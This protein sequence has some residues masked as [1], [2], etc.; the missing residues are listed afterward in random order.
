MDTTTHA[1]QEVIDKMTK[2]ARLCFENRIIDNILRT[3]MITHYPHI[4]LRGF[5]PSI[6]YSKYTI[7]NSRNDIEVAYN[8]N[9]ENSQC[10]KMQKEFDHLIYMT[11]EEIRHRQQ[12]E[13]QWNEWEDI[14]VKHGTTTQIPISTYRDHM[15][16]NYLHMIAYACINRASYTYADIS[17][18]NNL[19]KTIDFTNNSELLCENML[20][21]TPLQ[22]LLYCDEF[23][24][25]VETI[26]LRLDIIKRFS[27]LCL[28][29]WSDKWIVLNNDTFINNINY[30]VKQAEYIYGF[31][32]IYII[33]THKLP[34]IF[35]RLFA[36]GYKLKTNHIL[37][38]NDL[39]HETI[40]TQIL[41]FP[42][43]H[44]ITFWLSYLDNQNFESM[45]PL[46]EARNQIIKLD[47]LNLY[48]SKYIKI[49]NKNGN[50]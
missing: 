23:S 12:H 14:Y 25:L 32:T 37:F 21:E 30:V 42:S 3:S 2:I 16:N 31:L 47:I 39:L 40:R 29:N 41:N 9:S 20:G 10:S 45:R 17:N 13:I 4:R 33:L 49:G 46:I 43:W 5:K 38:K 19:F 8:C 48:F 7:I 36:A 22:I 28:R 6:L 24:Q 1:P 27:A 44:N 15:G 50:F 11:C 34:S 26:L 18:V 35:S